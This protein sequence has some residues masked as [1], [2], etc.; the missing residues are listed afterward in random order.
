MPWTRR[1]VK[2]LLSSGSPLSGAQKEKMKGE[3]HENPAMGHEKKGSK[4]MKH[5]IHRMEIEVHRGPKMEVTGH[6]VHHHMMPKS[7]KK[8]G[9]FMQTEHHA[10]SFDADG[11]SAEHG[12]LSDH[13]AEHLGISQPEPHERAED[14]EGEAETMKEY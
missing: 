1:Q 9:A 10:Y 8:S 7:T 6:T 3:L 12:H 13:V 5:N 14:N 11:H 2:Y 4:A